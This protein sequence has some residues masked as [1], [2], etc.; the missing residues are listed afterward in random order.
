M[1]RRREPGVANGLPSDGEMCV[2]VQVRI[3]GGLREGDRRRC[4]PSDLGHGQH[5]A[6]GGLAVHEQLPAG[7]QVR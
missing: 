7:P 5:A 2:A 3:E 4:V 6:I 1:A